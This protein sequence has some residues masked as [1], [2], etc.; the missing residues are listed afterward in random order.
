MSD[1]VVLCKGRLSIKHL[2]KKCSRRAVVVRRSPEVTYQKINKSRLTDHLIKYR[3]REK[4][5]LSTI[6]FK[7]L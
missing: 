3:K 2:S 6:D 4:E 5:R 1:R 7:E